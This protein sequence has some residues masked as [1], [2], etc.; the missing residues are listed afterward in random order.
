MEAVFICPSQQSP[1]AV[2]VNKPPEEGPVEVAA[3]AVVDEAPLGV[4]L[5]SVRVRE[6]SVVAEAALHCGATAGAA[7]RARAR[8]SQHA[9]RA[10]REQRVALEDGLRGLARCKVRDLP[11][12]PRALLLALALDA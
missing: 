10:L 3:Q 11:L 12:P 6:H 4:R 9:A 8:R 2:S 5:R 1:P 7:V